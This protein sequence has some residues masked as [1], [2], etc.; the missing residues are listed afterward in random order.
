MSREWA[1]KRGFLEDVGAL[2]QM[3]MMDRGRIGIMGNVGMISINVR[4]KESRRT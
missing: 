4:D 1:G 2:G 3:V